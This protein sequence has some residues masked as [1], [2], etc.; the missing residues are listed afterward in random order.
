MVCAAALAVALSHTAPPAD[1][2]HAAPA[3]TAVT[4]RTL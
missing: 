1:P 3:G 2:D 4:A